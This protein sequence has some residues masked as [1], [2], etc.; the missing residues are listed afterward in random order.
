MCFV[1]LL[2]L[3]DIV[4]VFDLLGICLDG[5]TLWVGVFVWYWDF[6]DSGVVCEYL[7]LFV[8]VVVWIGD[9]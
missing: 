5:D 6:E 7:L 2:V 1:N 4:R 9:G 8:D 3:V